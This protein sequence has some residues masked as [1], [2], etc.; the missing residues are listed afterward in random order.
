MMAAFSAAE[1]GAKVVLME[2]NPVLGKKL[3]LTGGGRCNFTNSAEIKEF[4]RYFFHGGKFLRDSFIRFSNKDL[5]K[6]FRKQGLGIKEEKDGRVFPLVDR[7]ADVI[8]TLRQSLEK[9]GVILKYNCRVK[10][11]L[12]RNKIVYGVRLEKG[13]IVTGRSVVISAGGI[14]YPETGSNGDGFRLAAGLGH[15]I[16]SPRPGLVGLRLA[17]SYAEK[18]EGLTIPGVKLVFKTKRR[19][20]I[21]RGDLLFT[22][23]GVSGPAVLSAS[24]LLSESLSVG[25]RVPLIVDFFPDISTPALEKQII[26]QWE[27]HPGRTLSV[28]LGNIIPRRFASLIMEINNILPGKQ[29]SYVTRAERLSIVKFLKEMSFDVIGTSPARQ[30]MVTQGGVKLSGVFPKT[31]ESRLVKGVYFAGEVMDIDADTGGFNLQ[32]AFSTGYCA[33]KAAACPR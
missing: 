22:A 27:K 7:A 30:A 4:S 5:M 18:L 21:K 20:V 1:S 11:I 24:S 19:K 16:V 9:K 6:F 25:E 12:I 32:A 33:G 29:V 8:R 10:Q 14:T 2:K 3:L 13:G 23:R 28:S 31:M 17:G 15:D 26:S